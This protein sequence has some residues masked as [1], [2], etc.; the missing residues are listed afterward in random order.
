M[1]YLLYY[2]RGGQAFIATGL[3]EGFESQYI[4]KVFANALGKP[5]QWNWREYPSPLETQATLKILRGESSPPDL[6]EVAI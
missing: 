3:K 2:L 5:E 6:K 1:E 4:R